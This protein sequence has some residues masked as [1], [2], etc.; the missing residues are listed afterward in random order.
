MAADPDFALALDCWSLGQTS[1]DMLHTAQESPT[2]FG[3]DEMTAIADTMDRL[4]EIVE[5]VVAARRERA[6]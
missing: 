1:R 4:V 6:A 2:A 3:V 5:L